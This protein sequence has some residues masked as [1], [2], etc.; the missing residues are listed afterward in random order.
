M[1]Q[2]FVARGAGPVLLVSVI[3]DFREASYNWTN[4]ERE[5]KG[6]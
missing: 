5:H 4:V 3:L 6:V 2:K 1:C